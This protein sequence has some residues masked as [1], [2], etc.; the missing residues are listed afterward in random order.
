[1]QFDLCV[2][3]LERDAAVI[4]GLVTGLSGEQMRWKP[5]AE[6]WSLLEALNHL[7]DEEREDFRTRLDL[8]LH[9][10]GAP[11]PPID[12]QGWVSQRRYNER[13]PQESIEVFLSERTRSI[14]W[15]QDLQHPDWA[16]IGRHPSGFELT[17]GDMLASWV[18]HDMLHIRQLAELHRQWLISEGHA[19]VRYAGDW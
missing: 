1:M 13:D 15:L 3:H 8:I 4:T 2:Q 5:S 19:D 11:W 16:Q 9:Q 7:I 14:R 17:A 12:P 6:A 10:P 18:A